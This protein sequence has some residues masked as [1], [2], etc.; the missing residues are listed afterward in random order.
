MRALVE[1]AWR[2]QAR[3]PLARPTSLERLQGA[4]D[5]LDGAGIMA[6]HYPD[7]GRSDADSWIRHEL[8]LAKRQGKAYRGFC[9][10]D[11]HLLKMMSRG[12]LGF[13]FG[14][15]TPPTTY[16]QLWN[17]QVR[18]GAAVVDALEAAGFTAEWSGRAADVVII[19]DV[20][21]SG[22]RDAAGAPLVP[23]GIRLTGEAPEPAAG[24]QD[25][26]I[27]VF[28]SCENGTSDAHRLVA[29]IAGR[30][31]G[32]M[33]GSVDTFASLPAAVA[34]TTSSGSVLDFVAGESTP[35][36]VGLLKCRDLMNAVA[37]WLSRPPSR[38]WTSTG[39]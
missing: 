7:A 21:W 9:Y 22:P 31:G 37:W 35:G 24:A 38:S 17:A 29:A 33:Y 2:C 39:G 32:E 23:T 8:A 14:P 15:V 25:A 12:R 18:V 30:F 4:F 26:P 16:A 13:C 28:V 19:G 36:P 34:H 6:R 5:A 10:Y 11:Q 27:P 3:T 20:E 1:D